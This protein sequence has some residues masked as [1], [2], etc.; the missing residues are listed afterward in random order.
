MRGCWMLH[1]YL[2]G[3]SVQ[4]DILRG[5]A[6]LLASAAHNGLVVN[7]SLGGDLAKHHHHLGLGAGLAGHL[8]T[9]Y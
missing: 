9:V 4:T 2:A 5:E 8:R 6:N 7:L 3:V 1:C